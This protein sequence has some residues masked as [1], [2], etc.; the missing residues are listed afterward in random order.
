LQDFEM[1]K[2]SE[3]YQITK[4]YMQELFK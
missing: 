2:G 1:V 4:Q 3:P